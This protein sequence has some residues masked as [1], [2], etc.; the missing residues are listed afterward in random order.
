[1]S[2]NRTIESMEDRFIREVASLRREMAALKQAQPIGADSLI[3]ESSNLV[4][5]GGVLVLPGIA[6]LY[7]GAFNVTSA[8]GRLQ[9]LD[10]KVSMYVDT[11]GSSA[12]LFPNGS[13]LPASGG[14]KMRFNLVADW[15][16]GNDSTGLQVYKYTVEN[17]DSINHTVYLHAKAYYLQ[18]GV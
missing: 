6:N 11:D 10:F 9:L 12:H 15:A 14:K 5:T 18:G 16:D 7:S 3:V 1:M 17:A 13:S 8:L 2:I 4:S